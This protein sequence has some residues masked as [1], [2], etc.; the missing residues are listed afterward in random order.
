MA[1]VYVQR[2]AG[3]VSGVYALFQSGIAEE[4][5]DETN[6]EVV[7]YRVR[8]RSRKLF[9]IY[10]DIGNL[11]ALKQAAVWTD[12]TTGNP[13]LW[14]QDRG[15]NAGAIMA[16]HWSAVNSG[17]VAAALNDAKRRLVALYCQ[18]V[19]DYLVA[20]AFDPTINISGKE[21]A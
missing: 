9:D 11:T 4:S 8:Y 13:P 2:T 3:V 18:D 20:P 12:I 6:A 5:L 10:T 15:A 14:S 21:V 19:P 1:N 17:A 7:A 16:L